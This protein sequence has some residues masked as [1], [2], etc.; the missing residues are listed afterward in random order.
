MGDY[1]SLVSQRG[2]D[3]KTCADRFLA[4][5][6]AFQ[7]LK[8]FNVSSVSTTIPA[9]GTNPITINHN[10]G[11]FVPY[12]VVYNGS[13]TL[14][15]GTSYYGGS[16]DNQNFF[17]DRMYTDRL[18]II[19]D[20]SFDSGS[21]SVGDTVYFTVYIFLDDF[22]S[23]SASN[24]NAGT[25]SGGSSDDY[26][27]RVSKTGFDGK[28]TA[29]VNCVMSSSFFT[30]IMHK[31]GSTASSSVA[32]NLGYIPVSFGYIQRSGNSYISKTRIGSNNANISFSISAGDTVYYLI[33]KNKNG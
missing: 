18:E 33:L 14:G 15:Q 8:V 23:Y 5:S 30:H 4:Y 10:L 21:S 26:G 32:H 17:T 19:I 11:R 31:K 16:S 22:S 28:T 9:A 3:G 20:P 13:T 12:L 2:Y 7:S 25:G 29:D 27:I 1:G 6:S 24:I